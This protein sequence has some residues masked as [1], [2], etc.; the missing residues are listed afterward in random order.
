M[1]EQLHDLLTRI[2]GQAG[3]GSSDPTLWDR[4]RRARRRERVLR[5][6]AA[7]LT[8]VALVG[9][10]AI[11]LG[12]RHALPPAD[13]HTPA[14]HHTGAGIPSTVHGIH[15]DGG[16]DLENDLA[17]GPASVAMANQRGAFVITAADGVYHRLRLPGYDPTAFNADQTGLALSPDGTRL[18]YG[19]REGKSAESTS[20]PRIGF[21]IVDLRT[22]ARELSI[23]QGRFI[24][25]IPVSTYGFGWSPDGR[26]LV[27]ET[28]TEDPA[29]TGPEHWYGGVDTA[30]ATTRSFLFAHEARAFT[31]AEEAGACRPMTLV[32]PRRLARVDPGPHS[33]SDVEGPALVFGEI[34]QNLT[35]GGPAPLPGDADWTVGRFTPDG[36]RLLL[37]PEGLGT[38]LM[39]VTDR[40]LHPDHVFRATVLRLDPTDWPGVAKIDV[41]GWVGP[42]HALAMVSRGTGPD[43]WETTG[44]LVLV[45]VTL[46]ADTTAEDAPV[47][48]QV[49][50]HVEAGD[51]ADTYSFATDFATVD[52]PT[53]A[54]DVA[55]PASNSDQSRG[56]AL[57][58]HD[59]N[60]GQ[61]TR[62]MAYTTA[63][64]AFL[65]ALALVLA[66]QRR[67]HNL[68]Q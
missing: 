40:D 29:D 55:S 57:T 39:L 65:A 48:I 26:Y 5:A 10:V 47:D 12:T 32:N 33:N 46:V 28:L 41:L 42:D 19:I 18:A 51:P 63:G 30:T 20:R 6:S 9:A 34:R 24:D 31:C 37:Q 67:K 61:T 14:P 50:G 62:L 45:D 15:G 8:A 17:V 21:R 66:R 2:A 43:T 60:G 59:H 64:M 44:K 4:A 68:Q 54:F 52:A 23:T 13:R 3:A 16:L 36:L 38:G 27:Y 58:S 22:G 25:K 35:N 53:Q 11:G 7:A 56:V 49:V 1:T